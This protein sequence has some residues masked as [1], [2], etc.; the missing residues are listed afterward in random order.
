MEMNFAEFLREMMPSGMKEIH[1]LRHF[2]P[3]FGVYYPHMPP[4]V[5]SNGMGEYSQTIAYAT[6]MKPSLT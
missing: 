3:F 5:Q 2:R 1:I 6:E 4:G